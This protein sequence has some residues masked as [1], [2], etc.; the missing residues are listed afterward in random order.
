MD[1]NSTYL[2]THLAWQASPG[3]GELMCEWTTPAKS[4]VTYNAPYPRILPTTAKLV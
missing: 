2:T 3:A 1:G 4:T